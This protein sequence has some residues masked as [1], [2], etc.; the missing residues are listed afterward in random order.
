MPAMRETQIAEQLQNILSEH[1][2]KWEIEL[3]IHPEPGAVFVTEVDDNPIRSNE[4]SRNAYFTVETS[5]GRTFKIKVE[6]M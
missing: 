4:D 6:E 1:L 3:D 2:R 5:E